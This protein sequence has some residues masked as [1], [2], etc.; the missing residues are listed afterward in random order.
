MRYAASPHQPPQGK[1]QPAG[2]NGAVTVNRHQIQM[3]KCREDLESFAKTHVSLGRF[4]D[5]HAMTAQ[6]L[7]VQR[8]ARSAHP[9]PRNVMTEDLFY[10]RSDIKPSDPPTFPKA[11][12]P[13]R[14]FNCPKPEKAMGV[15]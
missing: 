5:R 14:L 7:F 1:R 2:A 3:T 6:N 15:P 12:L 9:I 11:T 13:D 10:R 8:A 4:A